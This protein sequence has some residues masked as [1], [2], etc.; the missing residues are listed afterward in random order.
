[1]KN[2]T[3]Y[4]QVNDNSTALATYNGFMVIAKRLLYSGRVITLGPDFYE[5]D[6]NWAHI[7]CNAVM[8]AKPAASWLSVSSQGGSILPGD[9]HVDTLIINAANLVAGN[10]SAVLSIAHNDPMQPSPIQAPVSLY[11]TGIIPGSGVS[12]ITSIG[13]ST[14]PAASGT[15]YKIRDIRIGS[16]VSG[17]AKGVRY[18]VMLR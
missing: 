12:R 5:Y 9:Q 13:A 6:A 10:Y 14:L 2:A 7:L 3:S 15:L 8:T 11:V 18:S 16:S 4:C 1:M 17:N